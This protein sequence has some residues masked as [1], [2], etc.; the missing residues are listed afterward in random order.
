[1]IIRIIFLTLPFLMMS[2]L[3]IAA[4]PI[5]SVTPESVFAALRKIIAE[6]PLYGPK[7]CELRQM[8]RSH[9]VTVQSTPPGLAYQI[10]LYC[11]PR[12][13]LC[14]LTFAAGWSRGKTKISLQQLLQVNAKTSFAAVS[15]DE[16][17]DPM[18]RLSADI[19]A[20]ERSQHLEAIVRI[21]NGQMVSS[22]CFLGVLPSEFCKLMQ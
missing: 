15:L 19:I 9:V 18:V 2:S 20:G 5:L 4:Q 16:V 11:R 6:H 13:A 7:C 1:M 8:N 21:W 3:Q 17:G 10:D 14:R 12:P 22:A